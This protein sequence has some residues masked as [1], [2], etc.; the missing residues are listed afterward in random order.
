[1]FPTVINGIKTAGQANRGKPFG[2]GR[3]Y[4]RQHNQIALGSF[5]ENAILRI[6]HFLGK[7]AIVNVLYVRFANSFLEPG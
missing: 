4:A 1:M 6:D 2:R 3:A 7:E 5:S